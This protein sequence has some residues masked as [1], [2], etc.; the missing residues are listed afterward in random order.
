MVQEVPGIG[1]MS[2][3]ERTPD[4][5]TIDVEDW[6]H[7]LEVN[8]APDLAAWGSLESRVERNLEVLLELARTYD[9][10]AT[11][12]ALGWVA[13]RFPKL[14]RQA[15]DA[16]HEIASH[17]YSHQVVS[18]LTPTEFRRDI[19]NA[20]KAIEDATGRP[21]RGY[22]APGFSITRNTP[23]ALDEVAEAGHIFDSSIFP[24]PH[25]HGGIPDATRH[26]YVHRTASGNL[27]EFPI[28][29]A[30]TPFGPQCFFGGGYLRLSPIW[31]IQAMANRVRAE[32][33]GVVWYI[34]PREIDPDHPQ[35]SMP[36]QRRFKSYVNLRSTARKLRTILAGANFATLGEL[37]LQMSG[38][39]P[40]SS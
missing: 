34:H 12:F 37:A 26:P 33:R 30:D 20:K 19:R 4:V 16:G 8:G 6:F 23:W 38:A 31:L 28:S 14:L 13:D 17:G 27:I 3:S 21:V 22:R 24:A 36:L 40:A 9:I 18:A 15:A 29:V 11:C 39:V 35:L 7:I 10:K 1:A 2:N 32:G 5:F 25:G